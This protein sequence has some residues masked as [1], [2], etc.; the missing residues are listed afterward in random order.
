MPISIGLLF[1]IPVGLL[2][3]AEGRW[4]FRRLVGHYNE[5]ERRAALLWGLF[6][7][8]LIPVI[9]CYGLIEDAVPGILGRALGTGLFMAVGF[10]CCSPMLAILAK[11][12]WQR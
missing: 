11:E 10:A 4:L 9:F 6:G 7:G 8:L 2:F 3:Y 1:C 5:K 12:K